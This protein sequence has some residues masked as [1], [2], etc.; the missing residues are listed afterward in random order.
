[1]GIVSENGMSAPK[2]RT[3]S[4]TGTRTLVYT[5]CRKVLAGTED[6]AREFFKWDS[7]E[8]GDMGSDSDVVEV[9]EIHEVQA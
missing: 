6:Q 7:I 2:E 8:V 9:L 3:F 1:M 5:E 4:V